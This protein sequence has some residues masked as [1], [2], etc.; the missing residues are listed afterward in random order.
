MNV[1]VQARALLSQKHHRRKNRNLSVLLRTAA[2]LE[3]GPNQYLE[4]LYF[5]EFSVASGEI[6]ST[7]NGVALSTNEL[8]KV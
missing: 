5:H 1:N 3:S 4:K 2:E 6:S 7:R 8:S